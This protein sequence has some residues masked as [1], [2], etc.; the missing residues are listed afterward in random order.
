[1]TAGWLIYDAE[2]AAYNTWFIQ[3]LIDCAKKRSLSLQ[4]QI[5]QPN[6]LLQHTCETL[7]DFA[8]NRSRKAKISEWLESNGVLCLN[9][10]RVTAIANDKWKT[11]C[12]CRT[13]DLPVMDS[14]LLSVGADPLPAGEV[15]GY[16]CVLKS[17]DGHG[18]QEVFWIAS[19]QQLIQ[20][21]SKFRDSSALLQRA[22]R[23]PGQDIRVYL[24]CGQPVASVLR[25]SAHDFRS[26]YSLGGQVA[27]TSLTW[28]QTQM[29]EKLSQALPSDYIGVDF[30][31][32]EDHW[33]LN[34][35]E[36]PVGSRMLYSLTDYDIAD[37]WM[38]K[39]SVKI[40]RDCNV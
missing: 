13:L 1:M 2:D 3:H 25:R 18:G 5:L 37:E 38:E 11:H 22:S 12:L 19:P 36:D 7:P 27:L 4:L 32:Q 16:P 40:Q 28:E 34:E 8:I 20:Q 6:G 26:N 15:F 21:F 30:I 33:V 10:A 9:S 31:L 35:I 23:F 39:I 24:L 17:L 14:I 29:I